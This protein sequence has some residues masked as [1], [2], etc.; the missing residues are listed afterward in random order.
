MSRVMFILLFFFVL[1]GFFSSTASAESVTFSDMGISSQF[2]SGDEGTTPTGTFH[3]DSVNQ[4]AEITVD[5]YRP[6]Y[7]SI[8]TIYVNDAPVKSASVSDEETVSV[9]L[10]SD[11]LKTGENTIFIK[12]V[13]DFGNFDSGN[14]MVIYGTSKITISE[15]NTNAYESTESV[16]FSDMGISSQFTSGDEGTTPTGTFHIDSVNQQAEITVD[17]YRPSYASI[18]TIYVNDAPVKSASVSDEETVSVTLS[19]D[20]LKTGENTIFIKAVADFGNFDSGNNMVIYGTSKITI[21]EEV[22]QE[23]VDS[24][25]QSDTEDSGVDSTYTNSNSNKDITNVESSSSDTE[26]GTVDDTSQTTNSE[27]ESKDSTTGSSEV[28]D[29]TTVHKSENSN[30]Y[31]ESNSNYIY[32]TEN[33]NN[34]N[35]SNDGFPISGILFLMLIIGG[36]LVAKKNN[37]SSQKNNDQSPPMKDSFNSVS[38]SDSFYAGQQAT[39]ATKE[40]GIIIK[41]AYNYEGAKIIYKLSIKNS[42][43]DAISDIKI[44]LFVPDV[45]LINE[46]HKLISLLEP[47]DKKSATFEIRPTGECGDCNISG[48]INYYDHSQKKRQYMDIETKSLSIVCPMLRNKDITKTEWRTV[49]NYLVST[50]ETTKEIDIP[51]ETLLDMV[52]RIVE[53]MNMFMLEPEI[54]STPNMFNGVARF[55]AEGVKDLKYAAQIE[56]VGGSKKSKLILK[57]WAEKEE[58]LT[59]FYHGILD[60]L[61]KRTQIKGSI[62]ENIIQN[63]YHYG[64]KVDTK[65]NDSLIQRSFNKDVHGSISDDKDEYQTASPIEDY[66]IKSESYDEFNYDGVYTYLV[67]IAQK[68]CD[69]RS[70]ILNNLDVPSYRK[71]L[72]EKGI[73]VTYGDVL[74]QFGK[75]PNNPSHQQQLYPILDEINKNNKPILLSALV[76]NKEE[77]LPSEQFF[78]KWTNNSWESELEKIWDSYCDENGGF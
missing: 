20:N 1:T 47:N 32:E 67:N 71:S 43:T 13:A 69:H 12:A 18:V 14:D 46:T 63:Y 4:Q 59:G 37:N 42:T 75:I 30:T 74:K 7:A 3:I 65:I 52:S 51:A 77:Y 70:K 49:I 28:E 24:T 62:N 78:K 8:V 44:S 6:S 9:T 48:N 21:S 29:D 73:I 76:V 19:S 15:D 33:K 66:K 2:T 55:Y 64:D 35:E 27:E 41:S 10:S 54:S 45:F 5:T 17:T 39:A 31:E 16:S 25:S 26:E 58:A 38:K 22:I 61:E 72:Y 34:E 40:K 68:A 50:E 36:V 60:E 57:A 53:D 23:N 56:V 11:N